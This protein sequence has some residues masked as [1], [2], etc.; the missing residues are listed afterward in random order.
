MTADFDFVFNYGLFGHFC[1]MYLQI[2]KIYFF[3]NFLFLAMKAKQIYLEIS[4][5]FNV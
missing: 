4:M 5:L 1:F 3:Y 2:D